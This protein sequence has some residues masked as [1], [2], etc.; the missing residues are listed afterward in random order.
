MSAGK[1]APVSSVLTTAD[2]AEVLAGIDNHNWDIAGSGRVNV[3]AF[4]RSILLQLPPIYSGVPANDTKNKAARIEHAVTA[5]ENV[6]AT[7]GE[8]AASRMYDNLQFVGTNDQ[9]SSTHLTAEQ[10][11]MQPLVNGMEA[12]TLMFSHGDTPMWDWNI[13]SISIMGNSTARVSY[14]TTLPAGVELGEADPLR[15]KDPA[16]TYDK[17]LTFQRTSKGWRLSGWDNFLEFKQAI[18]ANVQPASLVGGYG[19]WE[20]GPTQ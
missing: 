4:A 15:F 3:P 16:A 11:A 2:V 1:T 5:Y 20:Q 19:W 17:V 6:A 12:S 10:A 9:T 13:E 18:E 14:A 7:Q 8:V